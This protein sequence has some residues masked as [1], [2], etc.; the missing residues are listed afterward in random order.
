MI[1]CMGD[2]NNPKEENRRKS[3]EKP[4]ATKLTP[5][6]AKLKL[7][8]HVSR[9]NQEANEILEMMFPEE[10]EKLFRFVLRFPSSS[11]R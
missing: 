8:D 6:E 9:G 4:T 7:I 5:Q 2:A 11:Q 1:V 3:Y 10:S